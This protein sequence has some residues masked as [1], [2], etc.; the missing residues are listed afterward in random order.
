MKELLIQ[1]PKNHDTTILFS[2]MLVSLFLFFEKLDTTIRTLLLRKLLSSNS[3][4]KSVL[5]SSGNVHMFCLKRVYTGTVEDLK[6]SCRSCVS[7]GLPVLPFFF[8]AKHL[9]FEFK[10]WWISIAVLREGI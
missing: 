5:I 7:H 3:G 10:E 2:I 6:L 8:S 1:W 9:N 4:S